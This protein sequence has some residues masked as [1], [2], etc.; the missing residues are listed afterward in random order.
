MIEKTLYFKY[1]PSQIINLD[2]FLLTILA[3][4]V[5]L[6][7]D[8][9]LKYQ[10]PM[11]FIPEKLIVHL[12]RLPYY[13]GVFIFLNLA[14]QILRI[15]CIRYEI[16]AEELRYYSGIFQRKHEFIENYRIKDYR[17]ERPLVYRLFGLGN[18]IIYTSDKTT[19]VFRLDAIRE[20][21]EKQIILRGLVEQNRKIKHVFE[22]D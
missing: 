21:E 18:L 6:L 14:Y 16:H 15:Y 12:Y 11:H 2:T 13:L 1:R 22:V 5:I 7:M 19:P 3:V 20:P 17:I 4:P 8:E 10:L 9:I